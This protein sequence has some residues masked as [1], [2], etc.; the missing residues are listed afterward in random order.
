MQHLSRKDRQQHRIWPAHQAQDSEQNQHCPNRPECHH[1]IPALTHL[2]QHRRRLPFDREWFHPHHLQRDDHG[3]VADAVDQKA[4]PLTH[5]TD[6][7]A[8]QCRPNQPCH[9]HHG[10]VQSDGIAQI[11]PILHHL[12]REGLSGRHVERIDQTLKHAQ[13]DDLR[14]CDYARKG[15]RR[16]CQRLQCRRHLRPHQEPAP[17]HPLHPDSR[18]RSQ[19]EG[20]DLAREAHQAEQK[21]R[22]CQ[23]IHQPTGGQTSHPGANKG[24]AL[25]TDKQLEIAMTQRS[26]CMREPP[27]L[28]RSSRSRLRLR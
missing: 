13:R 23:A 25:A 18:E 17:I 27:S 28:R 8:R 24:D 14:N 4:P 19:Q 3:K 15:E 21:G 22:V 9:V 5:G 2:R 1:V 26:P 10:R 20:Q 6:D 16:H 11:R 7:D 12:H